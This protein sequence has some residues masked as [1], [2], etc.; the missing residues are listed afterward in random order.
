MIIGAAVTSSIFY[1][2]NRYNENEE[3][4]ALAELIKSLQQSKNSSD[5]IKD[6]MN[7]PKA[8]LVVDKALNI[9]I[10]NN[11]YYYYLDHDCSNLQ[12]SS[13]GG[14]GSII[15]DEKAR[16]KE[17]EIM[18]LIKEREGSSFKQSVDLLD[19]IT[20]SGIQPGHFAQ[21]E[22]SEKEKNCI[23]HFKEK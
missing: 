18:I 16:T 7:D 6:A 9:I 21:V 2:I 1:I 15:A 22:L 14:I 3:K 23:Q 10:T 20:K 17:K 12:F 5:A 8:A 13:P 19:E 11:G 4:E